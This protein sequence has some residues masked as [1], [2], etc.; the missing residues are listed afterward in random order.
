MTTEQATGAASPTIDPVGADAAQVA[1]AFGVSPDRGLSTEDAR[2]RLTSFGPNQLAE[3]SKES[4]L[5][6]FL[7][8][9]QDFM[10]V[11]LLVAAVVN[12]VVTQ[13]TGTTVVL[14]GLTVFNA[15]IG[16]RQEA[17]AEESV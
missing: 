2:S 17:K 7:R 8:Q 12:Q 10:Q 11:I 9:Y 13:E 14:A 3:T 15:V 1:E 16:L 4:G 6:A 5:R